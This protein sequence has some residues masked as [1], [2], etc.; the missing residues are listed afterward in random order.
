MKFWTI[1]SIDAWRDA[2]SK[3]ILTGNIH[4]IWE[5]FIKPYHWMMSQM[6]KKLVHYSGEYPVWLWPI[7]PDMRRSGHLERGS[8][9]VLLEVDLNPEEVLISDFDAW[10]CV[11]NQSFLALTEEEDQL[12]DEGLI[13]L[14]K[15]ESWERIFA[16]EELMNSDYWNSSEQHLQVVI[17][18][19]PLHRIK[20]IREFI[21]K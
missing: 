20:L 2:I 21:A 17:G 19:I 9:G 8:H 11:L 13:S 16:L 6:E 4:F 1:Q 15:E 18:S 10:H 7:K 3:D 12:Y 14:T 5:E